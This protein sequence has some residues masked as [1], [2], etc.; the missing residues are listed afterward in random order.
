MDVG[1]LFV[2][3][4][5]GARSM[6]GRL[7]VSY[8]SRVSRVLI[9]TVMFIGVGLL[10]G[11]GTSRLQSERDSLYR[12]NQQLQEDLNTAHADRAAALAARDTALNNGRQSQNQLTEAQRQLAAE[13]ARAAEA[14]RAAAVAAA[15]AAKRSTAFDRIPGIET[16]RTAGRITVRVP[17]DVLFESG[18][19]DLRTSSKSTLG[20]IATVIRTQYR[21]NLIRVEGYTDTDPIRRSK[22]KD[23]LELSLQRAAS[24]H[25][26]LGSQGVTKTR[27]YAAGF[28]PAKPRATKSKS[29]RVEIVVVLNESLASK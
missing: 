19:V 11:C 20:Q 7:H 12:Q 4:L 24:V 6:D 28:G 10:T 1:A 27:M 29:R 8:F 21:S 3:N 5:V 18:K 25:R 23:N 26:F 16:E 13:R 14:A 22:W 9:F 2:F 17:G 15:A